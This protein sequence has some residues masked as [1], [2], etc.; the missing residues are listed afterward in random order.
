MTINGDVQSINYKGAE[1]GPKVVITGG[2]INGKVQKATHDG[3]GTKPAVPTVDTS[4]ITISG[5]S[6]STR[7]DDALLA[8]D[9]K[10]YERPDGSFGVAEP[11]NIFTVTIDDQTAQLAEGEKLAKPADP[12]ARVGY[13]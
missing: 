4:E 5:G 3:T 6:F 11:G 13:K 12:A 7:P 1:Q 10:A 2:T 8:T 9:L